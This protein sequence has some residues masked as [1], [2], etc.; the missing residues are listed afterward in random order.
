MFSNSVLH[1]D[2]SGLC[3]H[4]DTIAHDTG[5]VRRRSQKFSPQAFLLSLLQCTSSGT[6]SCNHIARALGQSTLRPMSRQALH[7]RLGQ[8]ASTFLSGVIGHLISA[9][10]PASPGGKR[11]LGLFSRIIIEDSTVLAMAASNSEAFPGNGNCRG[12]TAGC[13]IDWTYDL[14]SGAPIGASMQAARTPDQSNAGT[15]LEHTRAG[16]LILRD[17]GYCTIASLQS[18]GDGEAAWISR[19]PGTMTLRDRAGTAIEMILR[20][21]RRNKIDFPGLMS[22][23][24]P[25]PCRV[26]AT[27]LDPKDAARARRRHRKESRRHGATPAEGALLRCSWRILVTNIP[28][29]DLPAI[30]ANELYAFRWQIEIAFRALKQSCQI[31]RALGHHSNPEHI[32]CLV[33]AAVIFKLLSHR[34][35]AGCA[36]ALGWPRVSPE[37]LYDVF[38]DHLRRC[39]FLTELF[40][41]FQPDKRH[42]N[43]YELISYS[44]C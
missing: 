32:T 29:T 2:L 34:A 16:D 31:E 3:D 36:K 25:L 44:L 12:A 38:S 10:F 33:L 28:K 15:V 11:C 13:K 17:M 20:R 8:P 24:N 19:L 23:S 4:L 40:S 26:I 18:I 39:S 37:K 9:R 5:L 42:I 35:L 43:P 22:S 30:L 1:S 6:S 21:T 27:R 41:S 14:L 7:R